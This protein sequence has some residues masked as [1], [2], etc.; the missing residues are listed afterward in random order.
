[1]I[2]RAARG[3]PRARRPGR[4]RRRRRPRCRSSPPRARPR[5]TPPY[6]I[7][8]PARGCL[9]GGVQLPESGPTWQAMR[10]GRNHH[11][12]N[13][14]TIAFIEDLSRTATR[15]G[16]KRPLRRRHRPAARRAGQ[17]PR[18]PPDRPRRRHLVH[19]AAA[20]RPQPQPSA[21]GSRRSTCAPPTSATSTPTGRRRTP[22]SSRR[23]RATRG[24]TASSSPPRSSSR[25]AP[26]RGRGDAAWLRKI[27][28]VVG[29]PRPFP[30]PA[31][32][33]E[34]RAR[35]RRPGPAPARRRL[36]GRGLVGDRRAAAARSR[37]R[38]SRRR[39]RRSGSPTCR[40]SA[41]RC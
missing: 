31:E 37:T 6:S 40:R 30:R 24:S 5:R 33:P 4:A 27:R 38:R 29:P 25:C 12:G 32:L 14:P 22:T 21:S 8:A 35:L 41:P 13:P 1:M 34:G 28:P 23:R 26:T 7:G 9:A 18:Q 3:L 10:L 2:R 11:W 17:G 16:W 19:P 36:Q 20:P 39:S 15:A